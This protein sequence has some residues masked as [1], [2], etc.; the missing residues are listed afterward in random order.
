MLLVLL[1]L[2]GVVI[3]FAIYV[4][5]SAIAA[6]RGHPQVRAIIAINLFVGWFL[7]GWVVALAMALSAK[8]QPVVHQ[9]IY[10]PPPP[11]RR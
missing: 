5:P 9:T 10:Q 11:P 1:F 8:P 6:L 4:L 7:V 3:F 2:L